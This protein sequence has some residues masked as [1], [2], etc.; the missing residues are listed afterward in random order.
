MSKQL[1]SVSL[2]IDEGIYNLFLTGM[3]TLVNSNTN[4]SS[5][6]IAE[7]EVRVRTNP[8]K[9][10]VF[11]CPESNKNI[12]SIF[13]NLKTCLDSFVN[14]CKESKENSKEIP[15]H[16]HVEC[17]LPYDEIVKIINSVSFEL[18]VCEIIYNEREMNIDTSGDLR[19]RFRNNVI[20]FYIDTLY[21]GV[22]FI[23][24]CPKNT[25][26]I[27][28]EFFSGLS[29]EQLDIVK[30]LIHKST[31]EVSTTYDNLSDLND[32]SV[33]NIP[34]YI[35]NDYDIQFPCSGSDF[36]RQADRTRSYIVTE[37]LNDSEPITRYYVATFDKS[38]IDKGYKTINYFY[39]NLKF[40]KLFLEKGELFTRLEKS[41]PSLSYLFNC[42]FRKMVSIAD[43]CYKNSK[44]TTKDIETKH[45]IT[46]VPKNSFILYSL[47]ET[48]NTFRD[49]VFLEMKDDIFYFN[50]YHFEDFIDTSII[51]TVIKSMSKDNTVTD[52]YY[53]SN[54]VKRS[55]SE[56][57]TKFI[58]ELVNIFSSDIN[59]LKSMKEP[60]VAKK[61][62]ETLSI[63]DLKK[64]CD[65]MTS[66][67]YLHLTD[68]KMLEKLSSYISIEEVRYKDNHV[69][70]RN[71]SLIN[72][73]DLIK[74]VQY[75][76][77]ALDSVRIISFRKRSKI[78][79]ELSES[80]KIE[81]VT[82]QNFTNNV[83]TL[84]EIL[85]CD[86]KQL[87]EYISNI[88]VKPL[89]I[90]I[91]VNGVEEYYNREDMETNSMNNIFN[92]FKSMSNAGSDNNMNFDIS[93]ILSNF[94]G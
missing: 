3:N 52:N 5:D 72:Q 34:D 33:I 36:K 40:S 76:K 2:N 11:D 77:E 63:E 67:I 55:F 17:D 94:M 49:N 53:V 41:F 12:P 62:S 83:D 24:K 32:D 9:N 58:K 86:G 48:L 84:E 10:V 19:I 25:Y 60:E 85:P 44:D 64:Q 93:S 73:Y 22:N 90:A 27:S 18:L 7:A 78:F 29:E 81:L 75:L 8:E 54:A 43:I 31:I 79:T 47:N 91:K 42:P 46:F 13:E 51:Y 70:F 68:I 65:D 14:T 4:L 26:I 35:E 87:Q 61:E 74:N 71:S 15:S 16:L 66:G 1:L 30:I 92:M 38:E 88:E 45:V 57:E 37:S 21:Y 56:E 39:E 50:V 20:P 82:E 6:Y 80:D 59:E 89:M 23:T 69:L 28:R